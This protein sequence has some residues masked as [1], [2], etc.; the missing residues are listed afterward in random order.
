MP[1]AYGPMPICQTFYEWIDYHF[2]STNEKCY[3]ELDSNFS[4]S[5]CP[6]PFS[7]GSFKEEEVGNMTWLNLNPSTIKENCQIARRPPVSR[8]IEQAEWGRRP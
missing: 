7:V 3:L 5:L 6:H 4:S 8:G 1:N 2:F